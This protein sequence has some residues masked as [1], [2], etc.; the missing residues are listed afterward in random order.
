MARGDFAAAVE[1][2]RRA[3]ELAPG[4]LD[5]LE[6]LAVALTAAERHQDAAIVYQAIIAA[7]N[8]A[9]GGE[10]SPAGRAARFNLAVAL[11][12]LGRLDEAEAPLR[13]I[14]TDDEDD[15]RARFNLATLHQARGHLAEARQEWSRVL[16]LGESLPARERA[17]ANASLGEVLTD[18]GDI[19]GAAK[20]YGE[21][22]RLDPNEPS[23]WSNLAV[24]ARATGS[25]G[26]AAVAARRAAKLSP[27]DPSVW[28]LAG[29]VLLDLHR[30]TNDRDLLAEAVEAWRRSVALDPNQ[31]ALR[32]HLRMYERLL[33]KR[34]ATSTTAAGR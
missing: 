33:P 11:M 24:A 25:L 2:F 22:A 1:D 29:Q 30:A 34:A 20:A 14:L 17:F 28:A 26:R 6:G 27:D 16:A 19:A 31:P 15:V 8:R 3:A 13:E 7:T 18:L 23:S 12:R 4:D 9:A 21:A 10:M 5:V 32:E